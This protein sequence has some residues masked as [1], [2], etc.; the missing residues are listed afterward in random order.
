MREAAIIRAA[1]RRPVYVRCFVAYFCA[2]FAWEQRVGEQPL[3]GVTVLD[4]GQIYNGPYAGYL[5]AM[6]G[7]RV[8]KVE[9]PLGEGLRGATGSES[10]PFTMLNG[11]K[12]T[13]T[14][15]LKSEAGRE[16]VVGLAKRADVLLENFRPGTMDKFGVGA[17]ALLKE[18]P[19]LVYAASTG[20]GSSGPHRDYLAMDIT[21][22]AMSGVVSITG[23]DGEP[24]LKSGP[25]LCDMLGGIHLYATIVSA[26]YRR[27]QTGKGAIIDVAMQDAVLPTLASALGAYYRFGGTNP[28]RTGNRHQAL[29][30]APYNL[31][32]CSD[33]YVA[34]ICVRDGHWRKLADLMHRS[35]LVDDPRFADKQTRAEHM[36]ETDAA[37]EAWTSSLTKDEVFRLCQ[38]GGVPCAPVQSLDDVV[39][40][41]HLHARGAL[42][43]ARHPVFGDVV[44]PTTALRI[45]DV[46]P[47]TPQFPRKLGQDNAAVY[48]EFLGHSEEDVQALKERGAI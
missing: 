18:N 8:I 12:E 9:S 27:E 19:R 13:I 29:G 31:Y 44:V 1:R 28:P 35:D 25:A 43:R 46:K 17:E 2:V 38:S 48:G 32:P 23:N 33:G 4:F 6:A 34:I 20:Y 11:L 3:A 45:R 16:L 7:A 36:E 40:D 41:P 22:Q 42:H 37:V 21:V 15:N 14:I 10:F 24:P 39:N 26:L 47:P 5:L 30:V